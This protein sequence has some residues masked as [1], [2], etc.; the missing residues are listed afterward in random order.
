MH[1][2]AELNNDSEELERKIDLYTLRA[3]EY[4]DRY[5]NMRNTEWKV[6]FQVYAGYAVIAIVFEHVNDKFHFHLLVVS[7]A[8]LATSVFFA[9]TQYLSFRIQERLINFNKTYDEY[10]RAMHSQLKIDE[11]GPGT[12][13][14][15]HKYYWTYHT[16][17]I[18]SILT[19]AGLLSYEVVAGL[20]LRKHQPNAQQQTQRFIRLGESEEFGFDTK[21]GQVCIAWPEIMKS[22]PTNTPACRDLQ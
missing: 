1:R 10:V 5:E 19:L 11:L 21:T 18:L 12:S 14:L 17:L 15:G 13:L 4:R 16:Q 6:L 8:V 2:V 22:N 7:L 3:A 20:A 9:A